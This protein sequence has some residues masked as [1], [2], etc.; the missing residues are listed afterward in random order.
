MHLYELQE[1]LVNI[2]NILESAIEPETQEILESAKEEI[3]KAIDG[4]IE[5]ILDYI[6]DCKAKADQLRLE[7]VRLII[8][9]TSLDKKVD[10]LKNMLVNYM[11]TND[12]K[13]ESFGNWDITLAKTPDKVVLDACDDQFP[14]RF[15]KYSWDIDKT[16][17][18]SEMKDGKLVI[19]DDATG[20]EIQLAHTESG[21]S[22]RIK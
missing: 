19:F 10:Y 18:K 5:N 9:R 2:D 21:E 14:E 17:L 16:A 15:K 6:S 8:K 3:L 11:K 12:K 1:Q 22:L 13:K 4:K 20:K 7:T